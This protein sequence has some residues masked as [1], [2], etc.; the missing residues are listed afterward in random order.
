MAYLNLTGDALLIGG[1]CL[2]IAIAGVVGFLLLRRPKAARSSNLSE[3]TAGAIIG[4]LG[5]PPNIVS[6]SV[7]GRRVAFSLQS[8]KSVDL[9]KLKN[10]GATGIFVAGTKVKAIFPFDASSLSKQFPPKG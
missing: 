6:I 4:C 10:L 2:L 8:L 9:E 5:G 3:P 1:I 7:E